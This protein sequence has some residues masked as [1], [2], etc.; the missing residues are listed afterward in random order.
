MKE[1]QEKDKELKSAIK[2]A[3]K[4]NEVKKFENDVI[5]LTYVAPFT[6]RSLDIEKLKEEKPELWETY[7]KTTKVKDSLKIKIK[8]QK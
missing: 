1:K 4:N 5:S 2:E 3:M 6:R 7:I 8:G